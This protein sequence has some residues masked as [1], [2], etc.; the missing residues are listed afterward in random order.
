MAF[1]RTI[2]YLAGI[3]F[4][5]IVLIASC[6]IGKTL[7]G[8][9]SRVAIVTYISN[10]EQERAVIALI[11]SIREL[12][13]QYRDINIYIALCDPDNSLAIS[14]KD[15]DV[16][17]IPLEIERRYLE[18][19]LAIKAFAA[20]QVEKIVKTDLNTLIWMDPG[21]IVLKPFDAL[22]LDKN[23]D[24]VIRPV[25]L[26]NN[27]GL[28]P[29]ERPND[30][31]A[32]I[33][34]ENNLQNKQL[35]TI[36][37]I[38][39]EVEI[40]PYYNCEVFAINPKLGLCQKWVQTLS[41]LLE[42]KQYQ[43]TVCT[44]FSRKLFLHQVVLS[45]VIAANVKPNR[46][47]P[48]QVTHAY[49]FNQH[50]QLSK[51]KQVSSLDELSVVIFD[52]AWEQI[53]DWLQKLPVNEPLKTWLSDTYLDYL[54]LS[55]NLYRIEGSCN[56]YLITTKEGSVIID[57]AGAM[58]APDY[59]RKILKIYPLKTILL[60]HSHQDHCA[61]L[62]EWLID[63]SITI[64]AQREIYACNEYRERLAPFFARRGAIWSRKPLPDSTEIHE[65]ESVIP[66]TTFIDDY[67]FELGGLH[68]YLTHTPGETPDHATIW[69]P[70][71]QAVFVGDNYYEYFIN[72]ATLRGTSTRPVLGYIRTLDLALS[73]ESEYFL[74][75]HGKPVISKST[76]EETVSNLRDGLQY[77]YAETIKGIN[78]GKDVY[79]LMQE[80]KMPAQYPIQPYFGK[81]EWTIRGIFQENIGW[82]DENPAS[83]YALPPSSIYPELVKISGIEALIQKAEQ[84]LSNKEYVKVLHLTDV[85]LNSNP[86]NKKANEIRLEALEALRGSTRNYVERI[87]LDYG[88][89]TARE[90]IGH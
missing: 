42:D 18:Y 16:S 14:L 79:T 70:E 48:L 24:V 30:Y 37:T 7:A 63:S 36:K 58:I 1:K 59:F 83:M 80:I 49:P 74:P 27:I 25:T 19:P 43:A 85:I 82:F 84:L 39:D 12:S 22:L 81:V 28:S 15:E 53:P 31:W 2:H 6:L 20:A 32:P 21:V 66:N 75:G 41:K 23:Y 9:K 34:K 44:T 29:G 51:E 13:A 5:I 62:S 46:I 4:T 55:D 78:A 3:V 76:I 47:K 52:Y 90:K 45:G 56:S 87:W 64:I 61:N 35:Q 67:N 38:V 88:I 40:Q 73:Y 54:K 68:F 60:T 33:Y 50:E 72:N 17:L 26:S 11:K 89:R 65:K 57:P 71:L 69:I 8:E 10:N 86:D 77:L